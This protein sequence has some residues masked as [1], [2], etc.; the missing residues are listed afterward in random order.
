LLIAAVIGDVSSIAAN[1]AALP[2]LLL[3][4]RFSRTFEVQADDFAA[5][6]LQTR[7]ISPC[8]LETAQQVVKVDERQLGEVR[9]REFH[10]TKSAV[11]R[12]NPVIYP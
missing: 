6:L 7:G 10:G 1:F 11:H 2:I 5:K 12:L 4:N 9:W 8:R 3:Q